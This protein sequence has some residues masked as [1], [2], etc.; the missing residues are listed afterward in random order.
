MIAYKY[1]LDGYFVGQDYAQESPMQAGEYLLA[2]STTLDEPPAMETGKARKWDGA[3]W[4]NVDAPQ[5][6]NVR[7]LYDDDDELIAKLWES[8]SAHQNQRLD[9]SG[10]VGMMYKA[11]QGGAKAAL[12]VQ[13]VQSLWAVYYVRKALVKA[14]PDTIVSL[15]FS[16]TGSLPYDY[17]EAF[18]E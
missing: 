7:E 3:K 12:N 16:D 8:C 18:N 14:D 1:D 10:L 4:S 11:Q 13:W 17:A 2:P 6:P 9:A 5:P 15:N